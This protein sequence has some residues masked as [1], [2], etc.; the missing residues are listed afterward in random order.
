MLPLTT[1]TVRASD[2]AKKDVAGPWEGGHQGAA[3]RIGNGRVGLD[4]C[5]FKVEAGQLAWRAVTVDYARRAGVRVE[6]RQCCLIAL[7]V[8]L[9]RLGEPPVHE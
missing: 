5:S 6:G 9:S 7:G 2:R 4:R 8:H 1:T 3:G